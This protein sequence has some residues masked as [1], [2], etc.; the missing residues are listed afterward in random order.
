MTQSDWKKPTT[1]LTRIIS[2]I[3]VL[4]IYLK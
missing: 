1:L 2:L 3:T 4:V